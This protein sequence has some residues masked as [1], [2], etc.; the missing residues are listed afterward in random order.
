MNS[1]QS[2]IILSE[3]PVSKTTDFNGLFFLACPNCRHSLPIAVY[4]IVFP[5]CSF[6]A[7][8]LAIRIKNCLWF[9]NLLYNLSV[10][11]YFA[12]TQPSSRILKYML[13]SLPNAVSCTVSHGT[14]MCR[15]RVC[16]SLVLS[17]FIQFPLYLRKLGKMYN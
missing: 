5:S 17:T 1:W 10:N 14:P 3:T 7:I 12:R 6:K 13:L 11:I 4:I 16:C 2:L 15:S 9:P 8:C